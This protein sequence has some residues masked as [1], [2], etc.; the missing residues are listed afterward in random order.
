METIVINDIGLAAYLRVIK[1]YDYAEAPK[2]NKEDRKF[3]FSFEVDRASFDKV[4]VEYLNSQYH[5]F[6]L[7][8]K[9]LKR[10]I[11]S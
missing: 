4:R 6:D 2:K 1:G 7:E 11:N 5:L 3:E 10:I 8:I 9:E